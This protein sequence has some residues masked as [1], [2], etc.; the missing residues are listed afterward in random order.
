VLEGGSGNAMLAVEDHSHERSAAQMGIRASGN[1][2]Q[3]DRAGS[4]RWSIV[5]SR[6]AG[7]P[8]VYTS[9]AAFA[10][11]TGNDRS[12]VEVT[13]RKVLGSGFRLTSE[14]AALQSTV[15]VGVPAFVGSLLGTVTG[16]RRVGADVG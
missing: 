3:R 11:A 9:V 6:G 4:P 8:A 10:A 2:Y 16:A 1:V 13:G 12:S 7:D 5:W 15:S 14:I